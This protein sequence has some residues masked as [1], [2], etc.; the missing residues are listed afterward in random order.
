MFY[1]LRVRNQFITILGECMMPTN[2]EC[3]TLANNIF[4]QGIRNF[5]PI[6]KKRGL[7]HRDG[8]FFCIFHMLK[9]FN[10]FSSKELIEYPDLHGMG[11]IP[12][13]DTKDR[14]Q[15]ALWNEYGVG[16][17]PDWML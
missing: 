13:F 16:V 12:N 11:Q 10:T 9:E 15:K 3:S 2:P 14:L 5:G 8:A 1:N 17:T 7:S 4:V 6:A